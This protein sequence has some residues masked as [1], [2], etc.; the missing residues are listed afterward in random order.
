MRT[1]VVTFDCLSNCT[2]QIWFW[3]GKRKA[4]D[5]QLIIDLERSPYVTALLMHGTI[6]DHPSE[7]FTRKPQSEMKNARDRPTQLSVNHHLL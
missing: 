2:R 1:K 7:I 5:V 4:N 3:V 6:F